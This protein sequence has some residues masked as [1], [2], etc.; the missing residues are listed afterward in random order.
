MKGELTPDEVRIGDEVFTL[1]KLDLTL[2]EVEREV[3]KRYQYGEYVFYEHASPII[4]TGLVEPH[5]GIFK[6]N[7][8]DPQ[9]PFF[10]K[11][12]FKDMLEY[13]QR[14]FGDENHAS[15]YLPAR[16]Y[17]DARVF[18]ERLEAASK[19]FT[20]ALKRRDDLPEKRSF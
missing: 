17:A 14:K 13:G 8:E 2:S 15:L 12:R 1:V 5:A 4:N 20:A 7:Y 3:T 16:S 18:M 9:A 6:R 19:A 10:F 11:V